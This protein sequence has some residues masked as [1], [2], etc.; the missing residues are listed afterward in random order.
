M[1]EA[2]KRL[3]FSVIIPT[4]NRAAL[5]EIALRSVLEQR[6]RNFEVIVVNDGSSEEHEVRTRELVEAAE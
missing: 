2:K 4:R 1:T 6:F 5:F 3:L